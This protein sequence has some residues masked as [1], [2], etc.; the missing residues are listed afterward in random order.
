MIYLPAFWVGILLQL[1]MRI[2]LQVIKFNFLR[3]LTYPLEIV[4]SLLRNSLRIV[5][6]VIFWTLVLETSNKGVTL[7]S[8][9]SYFLIS[10]AIGDLLMADNTNFGRTIRKEVQRGRISQSLIKPL[11]LI[12]YYYATTIGQMAIKEIFSIF[13]LIIGLLIAPPKSFTSILLFI[14]FLIIAF[15]VAFAYN[16]FEG[17]LSLVFTEV[18]G[19][20][21][22][23]HHITRVLS[24]LM[25]P[26]TFFPDALRNIINLTP[27][28]VMIFGPTNALTIDTFDP[29]VLKSLLI[30]VFW[31]ALL[32]ILV[33]KFWNSAFKKYE[34]IG[35]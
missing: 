13:M 12:P 18:S 16:L 28:P 32:N 9:M 17:A 35:I 21:N 33:I 14:A 4:S 8:M 19:I 15:A 3:Y 7:A 22:M 23:L 20:K 10:S 34:A 26:L 6:L 30:G 27:F 24:G 29:D 5:F 31:A 2:Y 11:D 25:I 1:Y